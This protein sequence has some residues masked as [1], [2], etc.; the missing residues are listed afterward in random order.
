MQGESHIETVFNK[1]DDPWSRKRDDAPPNL[2]EIFSDIFGAG[3]TKRSGRSSSGNG[4]NASFGLTPIIII[5]TLLFLASGFF[6]VDP[7]EKA[8]I[9]RFGQVHRIAGPG[10]NWVFPIAEKR[11]IVNTQ[12][13]GSFSYSAEML[14]SDESYA[15]VDVS[16]FY[17]IDKPT[18]FLFNVVGP[19]ESLGQATA[20]ALRQVVGSTVLESILTD[21]RSE[22]REQI[23]QQLNKIVQLYGLGI[24]ITDVKLQDAKPPAAVKPSFDDVIQARE[25]SDRYIM[26]AEAYRN[27]V[28]PRAGGERMRIINEGN[29]E[30]ASVVNDSHAQVA[31]F[32][33]ILPEYRRFPDIVKKKMFIATMQDLYG[34]TK[35]V[36]LSNEG[37]LNLLPLGDL[38]AQS[39]EVSHDK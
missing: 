19:I 14:T 4:R 38:F 24:E 7:A 5:L 17:R 22:A 18:D 30:Y 16:V 25:D 9:I 21:G 1:E 12:K 3:K 39:A 2:E 10:P 8:V 34:K 20:S 15:D 26:D 29:A 33:S 32:I 31:G 36:F 11:A 13:I 35:K 6:I 28:I 37:N 27:M 23:E